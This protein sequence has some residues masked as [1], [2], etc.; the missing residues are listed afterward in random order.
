MLYS[1]CFKHSLDKSI[2]GTFFYPEGKLW[3]WEAL[4]KI[5]FLGEFFYRRERTMVLEGSL[6]FFPHFP[7]KN[8]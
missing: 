2:L 6:A 4:A 7:C 5:A 3:I 1:L 8:S